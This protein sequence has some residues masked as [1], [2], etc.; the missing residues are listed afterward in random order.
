MTAR[1][2]ACSLSFEERGFLGV[3]KAFEAGHTC[4]RRAGSSETS[5]SREID[6]FVPCSF[7]HDSKC[8]DLVNL[9]RIGRAQRVICRR[10]TLLR[11]WSPAPPPRRVC[12]TATAYKVNYKWHTCA[13]HNK[14]NRANE[15]H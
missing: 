11:L 4:Y 5:V 13:R 6:K 7:L 14:N 9:S 8:S 12:P 10:T 3:R 2:G 15:G 1:A